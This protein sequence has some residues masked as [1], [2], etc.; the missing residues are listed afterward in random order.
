MGN[1]TA[2]IPTLVIAKVT[3]TFASLGLDTTKVSIIREAPSV[4]NGTFKSFN[5]IPGYINAIT[6]F[7][8][9]K[10][11]IL[12]PKA[13]LELSTI[14][15]PPEKEPIK[16]GYI[17]D[18]TV[19][20][21]MGASTLAALLFTE[22]EI[23]LGYE[24]ENL[25]VP[26]DTIAQQRTV[27]ENRSDKTS[28]GLLF[29]EIGLNELD[30]TEAASVAIA[31][32]QA[33]INVIASTKA[34]SCILVIKTMTPCKER[35]MNLYSPNGEAANQK[36]LDIDEAIKGN[37][38]NAITGVNYRI[39]EHTEALND[40]EGNLKLYFQATPVDGIHPNNLGKK[41]IIDIDRLKLYEYGVL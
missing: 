24:A 14:V 40:G 22:D 16:V 32:L 6:G 26:G 15:S 34:E 39:S 10:R 28:F 30:P 9:G 12:Y 13:D 8:Q 1:I 17:G 37:G 7:T 5:P 4:A 11:Y 33:F 18:S 36:K 31:R 20:A 29:V 19:A 3:A 35:L 25:A 23:A 27:W 21:W 38:P 41:P 2:N